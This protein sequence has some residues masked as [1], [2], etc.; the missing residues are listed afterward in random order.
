MHGT[1]H[2][3]ALRPP[4]NE[5]CLQCHGPQ[6]QPGPPGTLEQ[7]THHAADSEGSK[8]VACHMPPIARTVGNVNVRSHT[9]KF[10][11]PATT[12][13]WRSES[14]H[15]VPQGPIADWAIEALK[16]WPTC[17]RWRVAG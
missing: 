13:D 8:C 17:R 6:L 15:L 3:A 7:H 1:K 14:V 5:V 2:E 11:S 12:D 4:G 9:F 10:I 16:K